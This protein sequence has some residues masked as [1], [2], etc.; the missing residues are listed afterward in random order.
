[1]T[2]PDMVIAARDV[3]LTLGDTRGRSAGI[4]LAGRARHQRRAARRVGI[5]QVVADGGADRAGARERRAGRR[6]RARLRRAGRGR[7]GPG[8]ARAD[9][10]RA[11]G[12]P[13]AADDDRAGEC[14]GAAGAGGRRRRVRPRAAAE[15]AAVGLGHRLDHYPAQLSGGEQQRVAI[16]RALAPRPPLVFADEPTGNLDAATGAAVMDLL[17]ERRAALRRDAGRHHPR[18]RRWPRAATGWS[19]LADGRR[20]VTRAERLAARWRLARRELDWR[21]RG[22]RLLVACLLLGRRRAGGDRQPRRGGRRRA[23]GARARASWAATSRWRCRSGARRPRSAPR[24]RG[25]GRCPRRC[26]CRPMRSAGS[27]RRADPAEGRSMPPIRSMAGWRWPTGAGSVRR[28]AGQAWIAPA[29]AERLRIGRGAAAAHRRGDLPG[30]RG[31]RRRARPAGRGLHAR[32]AG[33]GRRS[34]D[35][36]RTGLVQPGSLYE[37]RLPRAAA[38]QRRSVARRPAGSPPRSRRAGGRPRRAT[39]PSPGASRF[40]DRMGE[41]LTLVALS[42]LAIAGIGVGNGV[43]PRSWRA[44]RGRSRR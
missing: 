37:T 24:W 41:F 44:R 10:H 1:M 17:F 12:L 20:G 29:L 32:A 19:T 35:L 13:P 21:F 28:P 38:R 4:D 25:L 6:R 16:A 8:A 26:G 23:G 40:V 30:R 5:G 33:A 14:R 39:A 11:P 3:T 7:A 42:A 2:D 43:S 22:L 27:R 9:R 36:G 31:H 15:L 18:C 34:A